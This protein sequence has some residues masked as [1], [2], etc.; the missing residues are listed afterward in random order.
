MRIEWIDCIKAI[1]IIAVLT[2]HTN[3]LVYSNQ[4]IAQA[5]YF[6]VSLFIILSG[7]SIWIRDTRKQITFSHQIRKIKAILV[8]YAV[9][10][11]LVLVGNA[12]FF[13]LKTYILYLLNFS[14]Q[15]PYYFLLFFIQLLVVAPIL[16]RWCKFCVRYKIKNILH[17]ITLTG[18]G[19]IS[20]ILIRYTYILPV[21]GGGQYLLGGTYLILYYL[22]MILASS[23]IFVVLEKNRLI[24]FVC[25]FAVWIFWWLANFH[26]KLPFDKYMEPY[27][28]SGFNPPSVHFMIFAVI[29]LFLFFSLF[30]AMEEWTWKPIKWVVKFFSKVGKNTLYIFM[31][32]LLVRDIIISYIPVTIESHWLLRESIFILMII[33]PVLGVDLWRK[34]NNIFDRIF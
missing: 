23:E 19:F 17:F 34:C 2:D 9:A 10:T 3:G 24:V 27:W 22:G 8:Q 4:L 11:F 16:L 12:H 29:T 1:A 6:S 7:I 30:S 28:G 5:S 31:G 15:G 25:S 14:I 20:S 18:V 13:D 33:I 26:S 21:H 32:H